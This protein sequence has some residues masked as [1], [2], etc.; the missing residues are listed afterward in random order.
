LDYNAA[1]LSGAL[2]FTM[3]C[4]MQCLPSAFQNVVPSKTW[5]FSSAPFLHHSFKPCASPAL[6]ITAQSEPASA[7][8]LWYFTGVFLEQCRCSTDQCDV[9]ICALIRVLRAGT[10]GMMQLPAYFWQTTEYCP[11]FP[12]PQVDFAAAFFKP[13]PGIKLTRDHPSILA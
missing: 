8:G 7:V 12:M 5:S 13:I 4:K 11:K 6:T 2:L 1:L 9:A 3:L 10:M